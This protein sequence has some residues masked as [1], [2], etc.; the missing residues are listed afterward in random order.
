[1]SGES[2]VDP[3]SDANVQNSLQMNRWRRGSEL[4]PLYA[5]LGLWQ[6]EER[7]GQV[8]WGHFEPDLAFEDLAQEM[9]RPWKRS[10]TPSDGGGTESRSIQS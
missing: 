7:P 2:F 1:M 6:Q 9:S 4:C 3:K 5:L 8:L 10:L